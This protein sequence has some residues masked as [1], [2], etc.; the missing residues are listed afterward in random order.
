MLPDQRD[1][2]PLKKRARTSS[3]E[4]NSPT[5]STFCR[6][7]I[8][9][10]DGNVILIAENTG[11]K[12]YKGLLSEV[13]PVLAK[14]LSL[15]TI[16]KPLDGCQVLTLT[17]SASDVTHL[18]KALHKR[19]YFRDDATH[20][21]AVVSAVL[22]LGRKYCIDDLRGD[23]L[24]CLETDFPCTLKEYLKF[25]RDWQAIDGS[26]GTTIE[27]I[28]L[29]REVDL[30]KILPVAFYVTSEF[31]S[32]MWLELAFDGKR[33]DD[34]TVVKLSS[35]DQARLVNGRERLVRAQAKHS[36]SW[37]D[38]CV[39]NKKAGCRWAKAKLLRKLWYPCPQVVALSPWDE[40]WESGLCTECIAA[41][42]HA[43]EEGKKQVWDELPAIF[44]LPPW[45]TLI[46]DRVDG[47]APDSS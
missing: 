14:M 36:F 37:L 19:H 23:A 21:F 7:E 16:D 39:P 42:K 17:D 25:G 27:V 20:P 22:R 40:E 34:G 24:S 15:P 28:R 31:D 32:P 9:Y 11:F 41:A 4:E 30:L 46:P 38:G 47:D 43:F 29:A 10:D 33:Q 35:E 26:C 12:V 3:R 13:S 5:D 2:K 18:F 8:W 44:D 45:G 6:S 1:V